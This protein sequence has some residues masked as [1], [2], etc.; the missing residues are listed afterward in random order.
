MS[1]FKGTVQAQPRG[2]DR[3]TTDRKA[4]ALAATTLRAEV[5]GEEAEEVCVG[6]T[7]AYRGPKEAIR[8]PAVQRA[9]TPAVAAG[10]I[11][12]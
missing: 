6:V 8:A 4:A 2:L 9:A 1:V 10:A 11:E 12:V 3:H 5:A 7:I